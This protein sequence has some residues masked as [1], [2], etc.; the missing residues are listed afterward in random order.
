[1]LN[2]TFKNIFFSEDSNILANSP[3]LNVK[4][5]DQTVVNISRHWTEIE[6]KSNLLHR[7]PCVQ[8]FSWKVVYLFK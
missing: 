2:Y 3:K 6:R 8:I 7:S 1:M 5:L 4:T